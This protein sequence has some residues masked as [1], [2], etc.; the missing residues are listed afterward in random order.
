MEKEIQTKEEFLQ[1]LKEIF[2]ERREL[3]YTDG[4]ELKYRRY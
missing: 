3:G 2:D 1:R 4:S